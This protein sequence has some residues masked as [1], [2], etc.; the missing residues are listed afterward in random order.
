MPNPALAYPVMVL[1]NVNPLADAENTSIRRVW[2]VTGILSPEREPLSNVPTDIAPVRAGVRL[3]SVPATGENTLF[4]VADWYIC[5]FTVTV[6]PIRES[7]SVVLKNALNEVIV[8]ARG[9]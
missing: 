1:I 8:P 7:A 9:T 2:A 4:G 6:E 5:A 3:I